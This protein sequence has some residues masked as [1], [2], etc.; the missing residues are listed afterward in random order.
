MSEKTTLQKDIRRDAYVK[1]IPLFMAAVFGAILSEF[2]GRIR[3][4][5][6]SDKLLA[7]AGVAL[8]LLA[9]V[10]FLQTLTQSLTQLLS[11]HPARHLNKGRSGAIKFIMRVVGYVGIALITLELIGMSIGNL[12]IG[13]AAL[14]IVLGV[15]AQ[16][17][18]A[19]FF[20]S[21]VLIISH[22]YSIGDRLL[23]KSGAMGGEFLGTI[24]DIGLIHTRIELEETGEITLLPNA[25]ILGGTS[26]RFLNTTKVKS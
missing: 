11:A 20:A 21:I 23:L 3:E 14:G 24:K 12:L 15:A 19:N 9:S 16:Q 8:F 17:A 2:N 13:G 5:D 26:I 25:Q 10:A 6:L 7:L 4:G 1:L 22:P 18:L